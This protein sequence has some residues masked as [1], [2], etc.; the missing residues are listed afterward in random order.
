MN[1]GAPTSTITISRTVP[2]SRA[3]AF[4]AWTEPE[5][6]A[7]WWWPQFAD[8]AYELEV[9]V[10]GRFHIHSAQLGQGARG[11]FTAVEP[12]RRL[13]MTW[14]WEGGSG[15]GSVIDEVVV[16]FTPVAEGTEVTVRHTSTEHVEGGGAEQ[17]WI[18]CLD[19]LPG[20][21]AGSHA[22]QGA[23]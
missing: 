4:A 23:G 14:I 20:H 17:G 7:Q 10:G 13:A 3:A 19:R 16:T 18:D 5:Q 6:L 9:R 22:P 15:D 11:E 2:A 21:L 8:T 1:T 12:G